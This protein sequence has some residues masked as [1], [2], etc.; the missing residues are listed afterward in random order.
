MATQPNGTLSEYREII[1][2]LIDLKQSSTAP[3]SSDKPPDKIPLIDPTENVKKLFEAGM[4]RQD[5]LRAAEAKRQ[6]DLM[7]QRAAHDKEV[8]ELREKLVMAEAKRID[9]IR[10]VDVAAV[11]T[12][13]ERAS[14][15][16]Q[17]LANQVA[18]SAETLR[19][20]VASTAAT[21]AQSL[22]Q[23]SGALAERIAVLEKSQY[24]AKGGIGT[25]PA[26]AGGLMEAVATLQKGSQRGEGRGE[27]ISKFAGWIVA[28]ITLAAVVA[29][30]I[31]T[32]MSK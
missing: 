18:S 3:T 29:G 27:G 10:A 1:D 7:S 12:A 23:V 17:V 26:W 32:V 6:D 21:V 16:A 11:G 24:E 25:V 8:A 13:S 9:A 31:V 28:G 14:Q 30:L 15:Q 20:L 22:S 2:R 4:Q 5:D 19:T